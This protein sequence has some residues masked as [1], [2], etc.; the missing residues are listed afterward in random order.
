MYLIFQYTIQN[1]KKK[2]NVKMP[3]QSRWDPKTAASILLSITLANRPSK[4][5]Y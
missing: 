2:H 1:V 5:A 3:A 4:V